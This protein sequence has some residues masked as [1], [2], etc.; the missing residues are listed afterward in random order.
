MYEKEINFAFNEMYFKKMSVYSCCILNEIYIIRILLII[1]DHN[2]RSL[3]Y[4]KNLLSV[5]E[6]RIPMKRSLEYD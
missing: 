2:E 3:L 1:E 6:K 4:M 5:L